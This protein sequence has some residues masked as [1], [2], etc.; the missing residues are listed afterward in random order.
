MRVDRR[1]VEQLSQEVAP[2]LLGMQGEE[3]RA[4]AAVNER[5]APMMVA[6][7]VQ[8][9]RQLADE[10]GMSM[11]AV[12]ASLQIGASYSAVDFTRS[13]GY[14]QSFPEAAAGESPY[15]RQYV[16]GGLR[17]FYANELLSDEGCEGFMRRVAGHAV[18]ESQRIFDVRPD[19]A[20]VAAGQGGDVALT[21]E[22]AEACLRGL[23]NVVD[24]AGVGSL[25]RGLGML[26][27]GAAS[28]GSPLAQLSHYVRE[29][30]PGA[31]DAD[32]AALT[33]S[34]ANYLSQFS[35]DVGQGV[36]VDMGRTW[37]RENEQEWIARGRELEMEDLYEAE[38]DDD[39]DEDAPLMLDNHGAEGYVGEGVKDFAFIGEDDFSLDR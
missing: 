31:T 4:L 24:Q 8:V 2:L 22:L 32:I 30:N 26:L 37:L 38:M 10:C 27:A 36:L 34:A 33:R 19:T 6:T 7:A 15:V 9:V 14:L 25:E 17:G 11:D 21:A 28:F 13:E 39:L 18:M 20:I 1:A 23:A 35:R 5:N 29:A 3:C 16:L 12:A